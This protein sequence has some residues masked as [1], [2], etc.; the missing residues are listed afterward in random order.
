MHLIKV[1]LEELRYVIEDTHRCKV[2]GLAEVVEVRILR[3]NKSTWEG[4][5]HVFE[6]DGHP[7]ATRCYAWPEPVNETTIT[8]RAVL[9]SD[10]ISSAQTAVLS[11]IARER[12]I[13]IQSK[14]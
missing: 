12:N 4:P 8:V 6:I 2:G 13:R 10:R 11:V 7:K 14:S 3:R 1:N 9:H 5:V